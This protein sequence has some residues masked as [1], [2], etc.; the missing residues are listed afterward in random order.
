[1][2]KISLAFVLGM[3]VLMAQSE[4]SFANPG[5]NTTTGEKRR[6]PH[7][8]AEATRNTAKE[9]PGAAPSG[10]P[11]GSKSESGGERGR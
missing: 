5:E 8:S 9:T 2:K 4:L 10:A 6:C 7:C 1:M 3:F 11:S